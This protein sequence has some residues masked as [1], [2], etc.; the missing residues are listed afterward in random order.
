MKTTNRILSFVVL[1]LL[2]LTSCSTEPEE[3]TLS[4][5][6]TVIDNSAVYITTVL[7]RSKL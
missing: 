4:D 7:L 6:K 5:T 1:S 2:F 3:T